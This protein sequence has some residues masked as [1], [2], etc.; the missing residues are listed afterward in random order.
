[1]KLIDYDQKTRIVIYKAKL[2]AFP[3]FGFNE[4]DYQLQNFAVQTAPRLADGFWMDVVYNETG[5]PIT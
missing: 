3:M 1:M 2:D 5:V 4:E